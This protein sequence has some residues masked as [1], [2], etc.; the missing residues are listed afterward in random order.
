MREPELPASE[1]IS[2]NV[3]ATPL[4]LRRRI[5]TEL[6]AARLK[7]ELTQQQV[8]EAMEWSLS[9]MNRI[10]K[11]KS[12]ISANDLKALLR[13][14]GVTEEERTEELLRLARASRQVPWW[15]RYKDVAPAKL[16]KLIDYEYAA[17]AINQFETMFVPGILQT[18]DYASAVLD[19]FYDEKS[20]AER[21]GPLVE[22]RIRRTELLTAEN[23]PE[24]SFLLDESVI[25]RVVGSPSITGRQLMHLGD[26]AKLPNISIQVVPFTASVHPG[27]KGPFKVIHFDDTPD[28]S[29]VFLES[30]HGDLIVD[31][32]KEVQDYVDAFRQIGEKSLTPP[33]SLSRLAKAAGEMA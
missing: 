11:A 30:P 24:F 5:R 2:M 21:V 3:S 19:V 28:E 1:G 9:K 23:A 33:D 20:S 13:L 7:R 29:V 25:H 27:M 6:L 4:L 31:D 22:L 14:Y 32:P 16:L 10:E 12:G 17:S 8:A 15:T 26:M 18:E